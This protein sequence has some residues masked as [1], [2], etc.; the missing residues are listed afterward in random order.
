MKIAKA[1]RSLSASGWSEGYTFNEV[2]VSIALIGIGILGF[3]VNTVGVIRGNYTSSNFTI[4]T[5]LAQDK[6]EQLKAQ[7]ALANVS[8]CP[9]SGE[10]G[11]TSTGG[12]GGIYDRCWAIVDSP[13]GDG[14]KRIDVSVSWR[15]SVSRAVTVSTLVFTG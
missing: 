10:K 5:N 12:A 6:M 9:D 15:D 8:Y 11:L 4:A 7:A 14:L 3:S 1:V 13:L 2:L